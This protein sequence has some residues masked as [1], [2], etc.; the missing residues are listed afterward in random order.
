MKQVFVWQICVVVSVICMDLL[1]KIAMYD[2]ECDILIMTN[3]FLAEC[4][5]HPPLGS[6][7]QSQNQEMNSQQSIQFMRNPNTCHEENKRLLGQWRCDNGQIID[8]QMLCNGSRNCA[9]GSDET[10]FSCRNIL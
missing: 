9:D 7:Y 1:G 8:C 6:Y 3:H 2:I 10:A 5:K 4:A